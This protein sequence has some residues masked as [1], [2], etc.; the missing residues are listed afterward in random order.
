[1]PPASSCRTVAGAWLLL[2]AAAPAF[3]EDTR[4]PAHVRAENRD[5]RTF[6]SEAMS[7]SPAIRD[8]VAQLERSDVSV[9]VRFRPLA[10]IGLEGRLRFLS[11]TGPQRY[12]VIELACVRLR[13]DQIAAFGHELYHA[14]EIA[15]AP[16]V[17]NALTMA[18]H[19]ERVG[20]RV[21]GSSDYSRM[22]ET[23]AARD[24]AARVRRELL[25]PVERA[26]QGKQ[27]VDSPYQ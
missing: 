16:S 22:Y 19:Y 8:L 4:T 17:V 7:K 12:V 18:A 10:E 23:Q 14:L 26:T 5:T 27:A 11:A 15:G 20:T 21:G 9:F 6:V 2:F 3:A 24:T 25:A 13:V 1:M